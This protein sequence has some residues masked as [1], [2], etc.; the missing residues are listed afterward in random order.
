MF[1]RT[2]GHRCVAAGVMHNWSR[3][4][5]DDG[6]DVAMNVAGVKARGVEFC[7][8]SRAEGRDIRSMSSIR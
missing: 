7:V 3:S 8:K 1:D 6:V 4:E 2:R 5:V